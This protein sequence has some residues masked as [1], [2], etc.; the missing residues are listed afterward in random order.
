[1]AE[2]SIQITASDNG[3]LRVLDATGKQLAEIS[4]SAE[5]A[6]KAIGDAGQKTEK[7]GNAFSSLGGKIVS[8]NQSFDLMG[9][10]VAALGKTWDALTAGIDRGGFFDDLSKKT[11]VAVE[12]L[13]SMSLVLKTTGVDFGTYAKSL[14]FMA[15]QIDALASGSDKAE[16]TF[17]RIG[18]TLKDF[19]GKGPAQQFQTIVDALQGFED[20]AGKV[21]VTTQT[22]GKSAIQ[23]SALLKEPAENIKRLRDL[24]EELGLTLGGETAGVLAEV[25]NNFSILGEVW[26]GLSQQLAVG[27]GPAL[28]EITENL[29]R[30][31]A[32]AIDGGDGIKSLG[33]KIGALAFDYLDPV[34]KRLREFVHTA[35]T[36]NLGAA[37]SDLLTDARL[38]AIETANTLGTVIGTAIAKSMKAAA[39]AELSDFASTLESV[40]TGNAL[41]DAVGA[42]LRG[43]TSGG[44]ADKARAAW[45]TS[46]G[47]AQQAAAAA[48]ADVNQLRATLAALEGE[49]AGESNAKKRLEG[50]GPAGEEAATGVKAATDALKEQ[51]TTLEDQASAV[52]EFIRVFDE[53][54]AAGKSLEEATRAAE[55]ASEDLALAL[56]LGEEGAGAYGDAILLA[57]Q[58]L[59]GLN[60]ERKRRAATEAF[61]EENAS[62]QTQIGLYQQVLA[63]TISRAEA[64]REIAVQ[65]KI[66]E[67]LTREQAEAAVG[68]AEQLAA[69]KGEVDG[70]GQSF[71][72]LGTIGDSLKDSFSEVFDAIVAGTLD[73]G[74]AFKNMGIALGKNLFEQVLDEKLNFDTIFKGNILDLAG[75]VID[76]LGGAFS[77]VFGDA[78][79]FNLGSIFGGGGSGGGFNLGGLLSIG[80]SGGLLNLGGSGGLLNLF[81]SGG[82]LGLNS[83]GFSLGDLPYGSVLNWLGQ[84]TGIS[85]LLGL[86]GSA[87]AAGSALSPALYGPVP[88]EQLV[89]PYYAGSSQAP[90]LGAGSGSFISDTLAAAAPW[91]AGAAGGFLGATTLYNLGREEFGIRTRGSAAE[92]VA[93]G[94]QVVGGLAGLAAGAGTGL[95]LGVGAAGTSAIAGIAGGLA[96]TGVGAIVAAVVAIVGAVLG[97]ALNHVP[98]RGNLIRD[99]LKKTLTDSEALKEYT[100]LVGAP[101]SAHRVADLGGGV[102]Y[103]FP[104]ARKVLRGRGISEDT[105]GLLLGG[106]QGIY[107]AGVPTPEG[108]D[109]IGWADAATNMGMM[110][111]ETFS[112][113]IE[114]GLSN[115]QVFETA[116][117]AFRAYA[118]ENNI[119]LTDMLANVGELRSAIITLGNVTEGITP[120]QIEDNAWEAF[121]HSAAAAITIFE[122][123]YPRGTQVA[124]A[125]LES[126]ELNGV[127]AFDGLTMAQKDAI[128]GMTDDFGSLSEMFEELGRRGF[129][130][131][132]VG[133]DGERDLKRLELRLKDLGASAHVVGAGLA[134]SLAD[135]AGSG[136]EVINDLMATVEEHVR[137]VAREM[138]Q[139][140]FGD[141]LD[142]TAIGTAFEDVFRVLR[143]LRNDRFDLSTLSG[144]GD[145]RATLTDALAKGRTNLEAYLPK[146]QEMVRASKELDRA[147]VEAFAPGKAEQA[148]A[149]VEAGFKSFGG[150]VQ[151]ALTDGFAILEKGG[152]YAEGLRA[153]SQSLALGTETAL[154][155]AI[156]NAVIDTTILQPL[157]ARH[158]PAFEY[159][160]AAG[161]AHGFDDPRVRAAWNAQLALMEADFGAVAPIV[162]D[163]NIKF[164]LGPSEADFGESLVALVKKSEGDVRASFGEAAQAGL[165]AM[166]EVLEKN[167][168]NI[169]RALKKGG[170]AFVKVFKE[171]IS[172]AV[173]NAITDAL[174]Q[175][176]VIQG[177][178][179]PLLAEL[180]LKTTVALRDGVV[181]AAE[182][183]DL[184][185]LGAK[186]IAEG[187][188]AAGI[189]RPVFEGIGL[190]V[191]DAKTLD[192]VEKRAIEIAE[193]HDLLPGD[194][195][196]FLRAAEGVDPEALSEFFR[197]LGEA[198]EPFRQAA[199]KFREVDQSIDEDT[200]TEFFRA[201]EGVDPAKLTSYLATLAE[202]EAQLQAMATW[203]S[204]ITGVDQATLVE[205]LK[206]AQ[207]IDP[208]KLTAYFDSLEARDAA[209][210]A[211]AERRAT[212][213]AEM[214]DHAISAGDALAEVFARGEQAAGALA[215]V[216]FVADSL[217]RELGVGSGVPGAATGGTFRAGG[218]AVVG[219]AGMPELVL[220]RKGGGFDVIPLSRAAA[221]ALMQGGM[222]GFALGTRPGPVVRPGGPGAP[223]AGSYYQPITDEEF[224][225]AGFTENLAGAI[226]D[227][228]AAGGKF[229]KDFVKDFSA[230]TREGLADAILKG[231]TET[232]GTQRLLKDI[233]DIFEKAS[234]LAGRGFLDPAKVKE[235]A[236]ELDA[237]TRAIVAEAKK[238]E[239]LLDQLAVAQI[240][241]VSVDGSGLASIIEDF[242]RGVIDAD[243]LDDAIEKHFR[244]GIISGMIEALLVTGPIADEVDKFT[245][246]FN[247]KLKRAFEDGVISEE[248]AAELDKLAEQA[249]TDIAA[250]VDVG[251]DAIGTI[252]GATIDPIAEMTETFVNGLQSVVRTA[253]A[254]GSSYEEFAKNAR[255]SIYENVLDG[256]VA[257]FIE[258]ALFGVALA[259]A[260][261]LFNTAFKGIADGTLTIAEATDLIIEGFGMVNGL[262]S[263]PD[264]IAAWELW[265]GKLDELRATLGITIEPIKE[266]DTAVQDLDRSLEKFNERLVYDLID[267]SE[268]LA[269]MDETGRVIRSGGTNVRTAHVEYIPQAA[270]GGY[271]SRSGL[272]EIHSG[273][274]IIPAG[275]RRRRRER[276]GGGQQQQSMQPI[277]IKVGARTIAD[278]TVDELERQARG[279]RR[280][281]LKVA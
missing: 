75:D 12:D 68:W 194:V 175:G 181:T 166:R 218:A 210:A 238:L 46:F 4:S 215:E 180:T 90:T 138:Q 199:R 205:F 8:L 147:L 154:K 244:D 102:P 236:G 139:V 271:V 183:A 85:G 57:S 279:G 100:D 135:G 1:M 260:M 6:S 29:I 237:K 261:N 270:V 64:E 246:R 48:S 224:E 40:I 62:I 74:D 178:L 144:V 132:P 41:V 97:T 86:T 174:V 159:I 130:F 108:F 3:A 123:D 126:M 114:N 193:K 250:V 83:G 274:Y 125:A 226:R 73:L 21:A 158:Q 106:G 27:F 197:L 162:F 23:M 47:A 255:Q 141:L 134:Q 176:A 32:E 35:K 145:F 229:V 70:I 88:I 173:L 93:L 213:L 209:E 171:N 150:V 182:Q 216:A 53:Q 136:G 227:A 7:S 185:N 165:T 128:I 107:A 137:S 149:I 110:F 189:L 179:A 156:L 61:N 2:L 103:G 280:T 233:D 84:E 177:R 142:T 77:S 190:G 221:S 201:A 28:R 172:E 230:Q 168:D 256:M 204:N 71:L 228:V 207:G 143:Q 42:R 151:S 69:V 219:E 208:A 76:V 133:K 170:D 66:S 160:V 34:I 18:L 31:A 267:V 187:N 25:G 191:I 20:S 33:V 15:Q 89:A 198:E 39:K 115:A 169:S 92:G 67:G 98:T 243:D 220:G 184:T 148:V 122:Q 211:A 146:I 272:A 217:A 43:H 157:I 24:A 200:L 196:A 116:I 247:R 54:I 266:V 82:T 203:V 16:A 239:P 56:S 140:S 276:K 79:G 264:F 164:G 121:G 99:Q 49:S 257:A 278:V 87:P 235:L 58:R 212:S 26:T 186:I 281:Y 50:I 192:E 17:G 248:E 51:L 222:P 105:L 109:P 91:L 241:E 59:R 223:S 119:G 96:A 254:D 94:G 273:E 37:I 249:G 161:L 231:F 36:V 101:F 225:F 5:K 117:A 234:G 44:G 63:G 129:D 72:G 55:A 263:D 202:S 80:G 14:T 153:F 78:G 269:I 262:L 245:R 195:E 155:Q 118:A 163:A 251:V 167:P 52:E 95:A 240:I 104:I 65:Q 113:G 13:T 206:A 232:R 81:G 9:K 258:S 214:Q 127:K 60:E 30:L 242:V 19:D 10:A 265:G 11:G 124:L 277:V 120:Q 131:G 259:P 111:A 253:F 112:R 152:T 188:R 22:L 275:V 45:A 252:V 268:A 38:Q